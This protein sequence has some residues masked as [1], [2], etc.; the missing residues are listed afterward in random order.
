MKMRFATF[1]LLSLLVSGC[2][3]WSKAP[4]FSWSNNPDRKFAI[5]PFR[6]HTI[7]KEVEP[8][9]KLEDFREVE[10]EEGIRLQRDLYRYFLRELNEQGFEISAIQDYN[11][12]NR[13]LKAKEQEVKAGQE[14]SVEEL[15]EILGVNAVISGQVNQLTVYAE[16]ASGLLNGS[17]QAD[18]RIEG[19]FVLQNA[20]DRALWRYKDVEYG[21]REAS[22]YEVS[23]SLL[24]KVPKKFPF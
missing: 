17:L 1:I 19:S 13:I 7:E 6:V 9:M 18:R 21:S 15:T 2:A 3:T 12:T 11:E 14:V 10:R 20:D 8:G 24:R 4:G 23:K 5:L 22:V 16:S